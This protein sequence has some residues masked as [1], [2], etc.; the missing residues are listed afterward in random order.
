MQ[1]A[2]FG[3]W[4]RAFFV[5]T[6]LLGVVACGDGDA[7][8]VAVRV[9]HHYLRLN[10]DLTQLELEELNTQGIAVLGRRTPWQYVISLPDLL[11]PDADGGFPPAATGALWIPYLY[12][13]QLSDK[14]NDTPSKTTFDV[15]V[16][17]YRDVSR[18]EG[19]LTILDACGDCSP[20]PYGPT[21]WIVRDLT[22]DDVKAL[23]ARDAIS[24]VDV[25][26][27]QVALSMKR[28]RPLVGAD[29]VHSGGVNGA[30]VRIGISDT[31]IQKDLA[32]FG[33]CA[34]KFYHPVNQCSNFTAWDHGNN[35]ASL[36]A[37]PT[38]SSENYGFAPEALLGDFEFVLANYLMVR[39]MVTDTST[40][41]SNH[42]MTM[43]WQRT[44]YSV[45]EA[46]LD[47]MI[48]GT[49]MTVG[50]AVFPSR[51][52]AWAAENISLGGGKGIV[53]M[54]SKNSLVVAA[55]VIDDCGAERTA[56]AVWKS[57]PG[58]TNDGRVKPDLIAPGCGT[59]K[60]MKSAVGN[61]CSVSY[62]VPA[63]T[64]AVA[65]MTEQLRL[66][67]SSDTAEFDYASTYRAILA[68][69]AVDQIP[70]PG[71]PQTTPGPDTLT[72]WGLVDAEAAVAIVRTAENPMGRQWR[73]ESFT[74]TGEHHNFC[75][76]A[77]ESGDIKV[78]IAWDDLPGEGCRGGGT[79]PYQCDERT[80]KLVQ[81][82]DLTV[83]RAGSVFKS[84][85][86]D[87]LDGR[88]HPDRGDDLNNIEMVTTSGTPGG[89]DENVQWNV[90]ITASHLIAP[91]GYSLVAS[92]PFSGC[93]EQLADGDIPGVNMGVE[94]ASTGLPDSIALVAGEDGLVLVDEVCAG[95][96]GCP[97][98]VT[99]FGRCFGWQM[100]LE[101]VP[102]DMSLEVVNRAGRRISGPVTP[103]AQGVILLHVPGHLPSS[104]LQLRATDSNSNAMRRLER[105]QIRA[106][107]RSRAR[108][109]SQDSTAVRLENQ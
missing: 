48:R 28:A 99:D 64:G 51:P 8:S 49:P 41:V 45:E 109:E 62:A 75:I 3:I 70:V 20:M 108:P 17:T 33:V 11:A 34:D 10:A 5:S 91:Q 2:S 55:A 71:G 25:E 21:T 107:Y 40:V 47:M 86:L 85:G 6:A 35:V 65:L 88:M 53:S 92:A 26:P 90:R 96:A 105:L 106:S 81:D 60:S 94:T 78:T 31:G 68:H 50:L 73:E 82:L 84:W 93:V 29:S 27:N 42:S 80:P 69:T 87:T 97:A 58:F 23:A 46:D 74:R 14:W 104:R 103:D 18:L 57:G 13:P 79:G 54:Q 16:Q 7:E 38:D 56:C 83:A 67:L 89:G 102:V 12:T 9:N 101:Q 98:C 76:I 72:G 37:A 1:T 36:A 61:V 66:A 100:R 19:E 59:P 44:G 63:V 95:L 43:S 32:V 4:A 39:N 22:L 24:R 15:M 30:G 77:P 52:Q